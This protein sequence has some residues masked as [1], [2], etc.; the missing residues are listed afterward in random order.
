MVYQFNFFPAGVRVLDIFHT[1]QGGPLL[2]SP[3]L[4]PGKRDRDL[5]WIQYSHSM[6]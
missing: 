2:L 6:V 3:H 5:S 4:I 1:M